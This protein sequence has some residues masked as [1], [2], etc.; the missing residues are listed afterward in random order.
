MIHTLAAALLSFILT[1]DQ[2]VAG[3]TC[4]EDPTQKQSAPSAPRSVLMPFIPPFWFYIC[5][6]LSR[7]SHQTH[8][9]MSGENIA[10]HLAGHQRYFYFHILTKRSEYFYHHCLRV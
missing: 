5:L 6:L 1:M 8:F 4:S 7:H 9:Q 2:V 10:K 3:V